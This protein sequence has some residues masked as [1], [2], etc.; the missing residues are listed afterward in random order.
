MTGAT[1]HPGATGATGS[2][3]EATE[4]TA[5][6]EPLERPGRPGA[7]G[8]TGPSGPE[9]AHGKSGAT[10]RRTTPGQPGPG[11]TGA[12]SP[13]GKE[14][15]RGATEGP[16]LSRC[17]RSHRAG[18][19]R[20][21]RD[22]RKRMGCA[23]RLLPELHRARRPGQRLL[24]GEDERLLAEQPAGRPDASQRGDG[25]EPLCRH[26]HDPERHGNGDRRGDRQHDRR[27]ASVVHSHDRQEQL[28]EQQKIG[29]CGAR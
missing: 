12:T 14:G 15:A 13:T 23:E 21:D 9:G 3:E 27:D 29:L 10:D 11:A 20:R 5:R 18:R 8:P 17:D 25:D 26:E 22:V 4:P 16:R 28:L 7:T 2:N 1:R 24:P 19:Q 6:R